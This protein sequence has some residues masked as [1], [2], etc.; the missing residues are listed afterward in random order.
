MADDSAEKTEQPSEKR[1]EEFREKGDIARSTDVISMLV[2]FAGLA[3]FFFFGQWL[4]RGLSNFFVHFFDLRSSLELTPEAATEM[5][6]SLA[7]EM[8]LIVAPLVGMVVLVGVLGNI[9]QVGVLFTAKP[10]EPDLEKLNF[11]TKFFSTFFNKRA[12]GSLVGSIAKITVVGVVIYV[13]LSDEGE[14]LRAISTLPLMQGLQ[15]LTDRCLAILLNVSLALVAIAA[16]DYAWNHYVM[17]EKMKMTKQEVKDEQKE[18]EGN[19]HVKQQMRKRAMDISNKRMMADVPTADVVV[20]NPTHISVALR[21]RQGV[22]EAPVVVAKGADHMAMRIRRVAKGC[23]VPMVEN[24]PLARGLYRTVKV[25]RPVP[26]KFFRAV[27]E[28]LAYV[29]KLRKQVGDRRTAV[30]QQ[31]RRP[32]RDVVRTGADRGRDS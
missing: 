4:Y 9:A 6:R 19:P 18:M 16:A 11:F 27:A 15:Y 5:G 31:T 23:G 17:E 8:A 20:N 26:S 28:V 22:D 13:T 10:L 25:G 7:G 24:K 1:R 2:L 30:N 3:Y 32:V 21:Y 29:Y 12:L 14:K